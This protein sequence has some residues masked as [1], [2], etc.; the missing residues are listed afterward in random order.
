MVCLLTRLLLSRACYSQ[1]NLTQVNIETNDETPVPSHRHHTNEQIALLDR[2][3]SKVVRP[4][5]LLVRP[6]PLAR[7]LAR[8]AP[9]P[10][11]RAWLSRSAMLA[12]ARRCYS[13]RARVLRDDVRR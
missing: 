8:L 5:A 4:R 13:Y 3:T 11:R 7:V 10:A 2:V 6:A 9:R 1:M 12:G